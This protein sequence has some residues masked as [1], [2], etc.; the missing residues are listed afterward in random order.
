[1]YGK[2]VM[3]CFEYQAYMNGSEAITYF[4]AYTLSV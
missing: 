1:M 4:S 2:Y 3:I